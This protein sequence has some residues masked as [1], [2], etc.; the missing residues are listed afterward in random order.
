MVAGGKAREKG[1]RVARGEE[2]RLEAPA[3]AMQTAACGSR[4]LMV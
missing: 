3:I 4:G 2:R 1:G